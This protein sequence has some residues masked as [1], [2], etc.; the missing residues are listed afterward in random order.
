MNIREKVTG[1]QTGSEYSAPT[2]ISRHAACGEVQE[3]VE[4]LYRDIN[5]SGISLGVNVFLL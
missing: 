5:K 4:G 3:V 1:I 2:I